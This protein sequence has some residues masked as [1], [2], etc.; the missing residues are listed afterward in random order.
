MHNFSS[1]LTRS[2]SSRPKASMKSSTWA[3]AFGV[4]L[5]SGTCLGSIACVKQVPHILAGDVEMFPL[6]LTESPLGLINYANPYQVIP[7][8][9]VTVFD[10]C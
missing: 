10:F 7:D 2:T 3:V 8:V 1:P 5:P 6:L 9:P 4:P